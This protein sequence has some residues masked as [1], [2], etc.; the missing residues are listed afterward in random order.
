MG[1]LS[2]TM[3]RRP[4]KVNPFYWDSG[5]GTVTGSASVNLPATASSVAY[6]CTAAVK[7][8]FISSALD[9]PLA[10]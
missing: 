7:S 9:F 4:D 3:A 6:T 2:F 1:N 5:T 10:R 8:V